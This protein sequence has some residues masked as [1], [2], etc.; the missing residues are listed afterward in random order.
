MVL[1]NTTMERILPIKPK[2]ETMVSMT[3]SMMNV[4][5]STIFVKKYWCL[6]LKKNENNFGEASNIFFEIVTLATVD[7]PQ[8]VLF[9]PIR[10]RKLR[11]PVKKKSSLGYLSILA[12]FSHFL[13]SKNH[14]L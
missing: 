9:R 14:V 11:L 8:K 1:V 6:G 7:M 3:P 13:L 12:N 4:N 10:G 5:K 2:M